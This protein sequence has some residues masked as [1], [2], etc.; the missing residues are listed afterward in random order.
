MKINIIKAEG[1][2]N[3]FIIIYDNTNT[4]LLKT[5]ETI[6]KLCSSEGG[7][8]IDGLLLLSDENGYDFKMDY[9]NNDGTWETMCANGARC[10]ALYMHQYQNK[11]TKLKFLSGDGP[12]DAEI[13][14]DNYV[15][16]KM[17]S[18]K[19]CSKEIQ[20]FDIKGFH[21]DSGATHFA[22]EYPGISNQEVKEL[23]SKI[24]YD[25]IFQPRGI[26]VNFYER[27]NSHEINVK[28]YEKGIED[29]M[30]S[31]GSGSVAC[32]YHLAQSNSILSPTKINVLG[33]ELEVD[34][35]DTWNDVWLSG[36]A[37]IEHQTEVNI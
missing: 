3:H 7:Q 33:G 23:G 9:Y 18:P 31:C 21:V 8:R 2:Q 16:L 32:V 36:P 37:H 25:D 34:F 22:V 27:I 6:Q 20:L 1:T 10:A 26:N 30:M 4:S 28:T 29:L 13:I 24:R 5:K 17:S 19:Y 14:A 12:H 35:N 15:R 11:N